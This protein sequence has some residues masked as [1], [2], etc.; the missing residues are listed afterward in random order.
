[1]KHG[2]VRT[3]YGVGFGVGCFA[4]GQCGY[5]A[6]VVIVIRATAAVV[7]CAIVV[8]VVVAVICVVIGVGTFYIVHDVMLVNAVIVIVRRGLLVSLILSKFRKIGTIDVKKGRKILLK[9]PRYREKRCGILHTRMGLEWHLVRMSV[10][11]P[12]QGQVVY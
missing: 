12:Q 6:A 10:H 5:D 9:T 8:I 3:G 4:E 2:H 11:L 7:I 1:M